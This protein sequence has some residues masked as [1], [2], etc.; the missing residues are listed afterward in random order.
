MRLVYK[1]LVELARGDLV[2]RFAGALGAIKRGLV[3]AEWQLRRAAEL[4]AERL[5]EERRGLSRVAPV[6]LTDQPIE[7]SDHGERDR[8]ERDGSDEGERGDAF[9]QGSD[10]GGSD[11]SR[12]DE[13][14]ADEGGSDET[15]SGDDSEE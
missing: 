7:E 13:S 6:D 15:G 1:P 14:S 11:E 8:D 3:D 9:D 2:N 10:E 12:A 4:E 5:D